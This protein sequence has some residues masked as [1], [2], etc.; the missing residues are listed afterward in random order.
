MPERWPSNSRVVIVH[1]LVGKAGQYFCTGASRSS[2]PA[3]YKVIAAVAVMGLAIDPVR[4]RVAVVTGA[5]FST[6]AK[7]YPRETAIFLSTTMASVSPAM[8]C[9]FIS[10]WIS[11]SAFCASTV[12]GFCAKRR[13]EQSRRQ[14]HDLVK[15]VLRNLE[16]GFIAPHLGHGFG[17][18]GLAAGAVWQ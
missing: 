18:G 11:E 13:G 2:L 5:W 15:A 7:P 14:M 1:C 16:I 8:F 6:S 3:W 10:S 12:A 17:V 9:F 4:N